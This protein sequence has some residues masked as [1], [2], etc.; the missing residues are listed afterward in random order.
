MAGLASGLFCAQII[1]KNRRLLCHY[2]MAVAG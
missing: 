1:F 2:Q